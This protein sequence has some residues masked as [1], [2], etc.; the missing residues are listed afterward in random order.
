MAAKRLIPYSVHLPE[1]IFNQIKEAAQDRKASSVVRDAITMYLQGTDEFDA[2]YNKAI[3]DAIKIVKANQTAKTLSVNGLPVSE[4]ICAGL[5]S[6]LKEPIRV[7]KK[8]RR[9]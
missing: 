8:A 3:N 6:L 7:Q 9:S 5:T 1:E 4:L 2:G